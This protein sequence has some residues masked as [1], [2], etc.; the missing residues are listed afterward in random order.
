MSLDPHFDC[1]SPGQDGSRLLSLTLTVTQRRGET[2]AGRITG[3]EGV[4]SDGERPLGE[5]AGGEAIHEYVS[6]QHAPRG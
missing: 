6:E 5:G 3:F 2:A 1:T 4:G